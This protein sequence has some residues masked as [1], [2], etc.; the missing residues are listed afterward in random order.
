[1]NR[2][3]I[4]CGLGIMLCVLVWTVA[5]GDESSPEVDGPTLQGREDQGT[6]PGSDAAEFSWG[7][8]LVADGSPDASQ[9]QL[10]NLDRGELALSLPLAGPARVYASSSSRYGFAVRTTAGAVEAVDPGLV[11]V[12]HIDHFHLQEGE[13]QVLPSDRFAI[14]CSRPIHFNAHGDWGAAFCDGDGKAYIFSE[15]SISGQLILKEFDSGRAHHGAAV[16][17][18]GHVL[19]TVPDP[20]QPNAALPVGIRAYDFEGNAGESFLGC[21]GLHGE[22]ANEEYA[23]FGCSDGVLCLH[24]EVDGSL[25]SRKITR[26]QGT[27]SDLRVGT[28]E[29]PAASGVFLGNW[30]PGAI[31]IIDP[32]SMTLR[33][34]TLASDLLSFQ[35]SE[36]G[37]YAILLT[38]D[39]TLQHLKLKDLEIKH[40]VQVLDAFPLAQGHDALRPAM[41]LSFARVYVVDPRNPVVLELEVSSLSAGVA[42]RFALP[43]GAYHSL[44][45]VAQP[46]EAA[47]PGHE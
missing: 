6:A 47:R 18:L 4:E 19:L 22:A 2:G 43:P 23:C 9:V 40:E 31:A 41:T 44:A 1:M 11:Y 35:V 33:T 45:L 10:V 16:V 13:A 36:D 32:A 30:G 37:D 3:S 29:A 15:R 12:S 46:P 20:N 5:C 39:G 38:A 8:L 28:L 34:L 17:A 26:P 25:S 14:R 24:R 21:P 7:R 42:R 27:P